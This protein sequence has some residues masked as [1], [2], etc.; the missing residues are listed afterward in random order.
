MVRG[1]PAELF[2]R[3]ERDLK[4][5]GFHLQARVLEFPDGFPGDA[6]LFLVWGRD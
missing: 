6:G 3:W 5:Q 4:G 1:K 2:Q